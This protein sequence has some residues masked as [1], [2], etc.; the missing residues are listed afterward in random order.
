MKTRALALI[1]TALAA[2]ACSRGARLDTPSGFATLGDDD[3]Y[4][5]RATSAR[6]VVLATRTE[7][8]DVAANTAFWAEALDARLRDQG[9]AAE[10]S[11]E[12]KTARGLAGTQLR[13]T[14]TRNG[15][16]HRYWVTVF[17]TRSKV[18]VVEAAGDQ[19]PFDK[20]APAV[21]HAI[22]TLDASD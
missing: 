6:G 22:A 11:R 19:E 2:T 14:A 8:N 21:D 15:R 17:A 20:A 1:I 4:S 3:R 10:A 12:V 9:Y 16:P 5:Y 7:P 13:Y 18:F